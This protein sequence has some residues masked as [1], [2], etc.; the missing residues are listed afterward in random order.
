MI[1]F[2]LFFLAFGIAATVGPAL[3]V[4]LVIALT[5]TSLRRSER[6]SL[7]LLAAAG[8]SGA[9]VVLL[10]GSYLLPV[11]VVLVVASTAA[12]GAAGMAWTAHRRRTADRRNL[13][14]GGRQPGAAPMA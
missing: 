14:W 10:H 3:A 6:I 9:W 4:G 5:S 7:L 2:L 8:L 13:A 12:S 11:A 1:F